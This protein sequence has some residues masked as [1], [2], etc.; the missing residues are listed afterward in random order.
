MLQL[1]CMAC[2]SCPCVYTYSIGVTDQ[3]ALR[4]HNQ[5]V[6]CTHM[7]THSLTQGDPGTTLALFDLQDPMIALSSGPTMVAL[8]HLLEGVPEKEG[9]LMD[10]AVA[11]AVKRLQ[12]D[13]ARWWREARLRSLETD[14][15]GGMRVCNGGT[16]CWNASHSWRL[17]L[18]RLSFL[19]SVIAASVR[20]TMCTASTCTPSVACCC[21]VQNSSA[22]S[23]CTPLSRCEQATMPVKRGVLK[24]RSLWTR[25]VGAT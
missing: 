17:S 15:V 16:M 8:T 19:A 23:W 24:N 18:L 14:R 7:C 10:P 13:Q 11:M 22:R 1:T 3:Q 6:L 2:T 5:P 21:A 9:G 12:G 25:C 4:E 20:R